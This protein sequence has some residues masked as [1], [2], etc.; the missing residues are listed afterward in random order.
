MS[1]HLAAAANYDEII[2]YVLESYLQDNIV[3]EPTAGVDKGSREVLEGLYTLNEN[4][5]SRINFYKNN[6][7][8][9][10]LPVIFISLALLCMAENDEMDEGKLAEAF[11]DLTD[12]LS[13]EFI[14]SESFL[15]TAATLQKGLLYLEKRSA[16]TR[17]GGKVRIQ[18][19]K[20][21]ELVLFAKAVQEFLESYL[22]VCDCVLQ[23][24]KKVSRKELIF[25][26]RKNGIKLFHLGEVKFTESLSMPNYENAIA[27]MDRDDVFEKVPGG[28]KHVDLLLKDEAK[29]VEI[30]GRVERYLKPLQKV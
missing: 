19:E 29:A 6:T 3:G 12:L 17:G 21:E 16:V 13:L 11:S 1:D 25:E 15:D 24:K 14:Y 10:F 30:K 5:R 27:R 2:D 4:E 7:I 23:V 26:V 22:V 8:H 18:P 28:K 9:Y 20:R